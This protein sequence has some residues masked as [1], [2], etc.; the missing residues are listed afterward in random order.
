M[1]FP[2]LKKIKNNECYMSYIIIFKMDCESSKGFYSIHVYA[3][4][5]ILPFVLSYFN[6]V[7]GGWNS[8]E[9]A[10]VLVY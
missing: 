2:Y 7:F 4:A 3:L 5:L 9:Q 6:I 10:L 1:S 8:I